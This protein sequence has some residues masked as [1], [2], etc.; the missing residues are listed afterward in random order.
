[1]WGLLAVP[2]S[3]P[4]WRFSRDGKVL[5]VGRISSDFGLARFNADGSLDA[6][7][8]GDGRQTTDFG[9]LDGAEGVAV[10]GDGKIVA[11]GTGATSFGAA[12]DFAVARYNANGS[13]DSSFSADGKV[14]TDFQ[15]GF[16]RRGG[17]CRV[18][19]RWED[20]RWR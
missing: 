3:C 20:R 5:A 17:R 15:G 10:Q 7:F 18:A 16:A 19:A 1:M 13:L 9:G 6:T 12:G 8:S 4:A 11:V 14:A 2:T